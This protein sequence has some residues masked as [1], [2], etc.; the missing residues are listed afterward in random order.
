LAHHKVP[1]GY[2]SVFKEMADIIVSLIQAGLPVDEKT[3][4]DISVG[5]HWGNHWRDKN[6]HEKHGARID[7]EMD[8]PDYFPQAKSNPQHPWAYPDAAL[9]EYRAWFREV[10]LKEKLPAYLE[11]QE[12]KRALPPSVSS[13]LLEA[14]TS[15]EIKRISK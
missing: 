3:V 2:F 9:P 14:I 4:P 12:K 1:A 8:Y 7:Y 13:L 10:Y 11:I 6:L 15:P 5:I